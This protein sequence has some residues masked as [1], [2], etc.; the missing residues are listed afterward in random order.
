MRA[1]NPRAY[2][3]RVRVIVTILPHGAE[4][5]PA[6]AAV[7]VEVR[8]TT[9]ED[10]RAEAVGRAAGRVGADATVR[11]LA[12]IEVILARLPARTTVWAHVDADGDGQVSRGDFLT[13]ASHPVPPGDP[14]AVEV[15]V[16]RI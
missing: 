2:D 10:A 9:Y 1:G 11:E 3:A 7:H 5:P 12:T 13:T 15:T 4:R 8:D 16:R 6:G 14:A